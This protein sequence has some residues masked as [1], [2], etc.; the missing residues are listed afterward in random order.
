[1]SVFRIAVTAVGVAATLA[2]HPVVRA[3]I[4]AAPYL[5]TPKMRADAAE[6]VLATAYKAGVAA[7]RLIR[8][9]KLT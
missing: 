9:R 6:A 3:G 4:K 1:M 7:R 2:R 5:I 8:P